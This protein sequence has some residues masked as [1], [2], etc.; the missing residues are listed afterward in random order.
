VKVLLGCIHGGTLWHDP[1]VSIDT[2][3]IAR[4]KWLPKANN[5]LKLLFKKVGERALSKLM[6]EKFQTLRGKRGLD[7]KNISETNVQFATQVLACK[8]LD[9]GRNDE[10]LTAEKCVE[11]VQMNWTTFLVN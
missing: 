11:G 6:K 3:M 8:L 9:K 5:D 2:A 4:I 7:V 1:L 10:V